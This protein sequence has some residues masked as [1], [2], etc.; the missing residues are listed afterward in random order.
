MAKGLVITYALSTKRILFPESFRVCTI[1][2]PLELGQIRRPQP[3]EQRSPINVPQ[4]SEQ[5][6]PF[7]AEYPFLEAFRSVY[8]TGKHRE[9]EQIGRSQPSELVFTYQTLIPIKPPVPSPVISIHRSGCPQPIELYSP[10]F[11]KPRPRKLGQ[12]R[13]RGYR[14]LLSTNCSSCS[15]SYLY[16]FSFNDSNARTRRAIL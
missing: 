10:N 6:S 4:P 5:C 16:L 9:P 13:P 11:K 7:S 1:V 15:K 8:T 14:I 12:I 3:S 2:R